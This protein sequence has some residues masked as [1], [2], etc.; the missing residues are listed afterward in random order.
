[1]VD[2][3]HLGITEDFVKLPT[4]LLTLCRRLKYP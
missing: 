1:L 2:K 4:T 3:L